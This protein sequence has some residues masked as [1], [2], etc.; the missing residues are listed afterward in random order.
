PNALVVH[1]YSAVRVTDAP[2]SG[3]GVTIATTVG[4][5]FDGIVANFRDGNPAGAI[6][7]FSATINWGDDHTSTGTIAL[8]PAGFAVSG[9]NTYVA[10]GTYTITVRVFD[11]GGSRVLIQSTANVIAGMTSSS[12]AAASRIKWG[13]KDDE[14]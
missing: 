6:G 2:L 4:T 10:A 13:W 8:S 11:V 14:V 5:V 3:T 7:D 12:L 1:A 9:S